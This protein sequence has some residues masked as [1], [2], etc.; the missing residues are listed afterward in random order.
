MIL[1]I[2]LA[3]MCILCALCLC[4]K[5]AARAAAVAAGL[6][7]FAGATGKGGS[8]PRELESFCVS[9]SRAIADS[10]R[11]WQSLCLGGACAFAT[12][13]ALCTAALI[14]LKPD[15]YGLFALCAASAAL[16]AFADRCFFDIPAHAMAFANPIKTAKRLEKY[17][18]AVLV[19]MF[20][21][22][23]LANRLS[24]PTSRRIGTETSGDLGNISNLDIE[25][26][27]KAEEA[28]ADS[29]SQYAGKIA[30]NALLLQEIDVS[31]VM[32][33]RSRV[34]VL[35]TL[36]P[37][38]ENLETAKKYA[39]TRYPLCKGDLDNCYGFI[40]IKDI[41]NFDASSGE[42]DLMKIRRDTIRLKETDKLE[43]ALSKM[44]K[45]R[46]HIALVEDE[47]GGVIGVLTL[48]AALS[49]LVGQIRNEFDDSQKQTIRA[50]GKNTY[51]VPGSASLRMVEDFLD[52]DFNTDEVS[53]F[54]GLI[55]FWLGRFPEKGEH[56]YLK[57]QRI[58][59]TIDN[60][61]ERLVTECTVKIE[62]DDK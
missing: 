52:V 13:A 43:A 15:I 51:K 6:V 61:D 56:I 39:H 45:Y 3:L 7:K 9:Q 49:A 23:M 16:T 50:V 34:A 57:K 37:V 4:M 10:A 26:M 14:G 32:L 1:K 20:L 62:G 40:H 25:L 29:I 55:T 54:G 17:T 12:A 46:L 30:K 35:D 33:P 2:T 36:A 22:N 59:I 38:E 47:F 11:L 53:T 27:L 48:D 60:L 24:R 42:L 18:K 31:D 58:R 28:S 21:P 19:L 5:A 44:L 41:I 8:V